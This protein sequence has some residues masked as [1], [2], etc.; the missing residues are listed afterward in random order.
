[1]LNDT[2]GH[3]VGDLVLQQIA[4]RMRRCLREGDTVARMGGDEFTL[5]LPNVSG[6]VEAARVAERLLEALR[7]PILIQEGEFPISVSLG[8][9][10]FPQDAITADELLRLADAALYRAKARGKATFELYSG[11]H[12]SRLS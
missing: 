3:L 12:P 7:A 2:H 11:R 6:S 4:T 1:V 10:L 8:L 5:L 9:S